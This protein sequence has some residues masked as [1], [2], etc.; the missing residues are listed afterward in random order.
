[1]IPI[2]KTTE[3]T[4]VKLDFGSR[5]NAYV[6]SVNKKP[7]YV[8][9]EWLNKHIQLNLREN[10]PGVVSSPDLVNELDELEGVILS[11]R[12]FLN[13]YYPKKPYSKE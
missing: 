6:H 11:V 1:M 5:V 12:E 13:K 8:R 10:P 4:E 2:P 7:D 3:H 9:F